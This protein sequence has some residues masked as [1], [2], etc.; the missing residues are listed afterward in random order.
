MSKFTRIENIKGT[1]VHP[2]S[3]KSWRVPFGTG[4]RVNRFFAGTHDEYVLYDPD[5]FFVLKEWLN[6]FN[7][8]SSAHAGKILS[9]AKNIN[10]HLHTFLEDQNF[11]R[12]WNK[13][14]KN[15][16]STEQIDKQRSF[17][18]DGFR[19]L[20][21][22]HYLRD[23]SFPMIN[24][25]DALD[26][27]LTEFGADNPRRSKTGLPGLEVQKDYLNILREADLNSA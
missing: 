21:L 14:I 23:K 3:R 10:P 1:T 9:E 6:L 12:D 17:W 4:Q 24:M 2:S 22:I 13:I 15:S 26:L 25:F 5:S 16:K 20:K 27:L 11:E 8:M 19:T 18:F 7:K